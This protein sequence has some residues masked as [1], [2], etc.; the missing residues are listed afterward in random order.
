M[1]V[2]NCR[3][4]RRI[5]NYVA[6]PIM[7][8]ACREDME[9]KF[10][11]VKEYIR[12]HKGAGIQEV[13]EICE[14]EVSTIQQWLR[15][16]RLEVMEGS[17]MMLNCESCRMPIRSGRYCDKCKYEM[18]TGFKNIL[19]NNQPKKNEKASEKDNPKM[20]FL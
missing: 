19:K 9:K 14:V 8:P 16:E 20:R 11:E 13:A 15:E 10:Q 5:F 12:E 4:C 2:R 3:K 6:G 17:A 18:A 1:D 7:C